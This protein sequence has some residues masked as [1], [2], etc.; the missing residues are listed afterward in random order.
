MGEKGVCV[1]IIFFIPFF[2]FLFFSLYLCVL[3]QTKGI[4]V[5]LLNFCTLN[6]Q[7]ERVSSQKELWCRR[8]KGLGLLVVEIKGSKPYC[9]NLQRFMNPGAIYPY[10]KYTSFGQERSVEDGEISL[11]IS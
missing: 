2:L 8:L 5:I 1:I 7:T 10:L 3:N 9:Y 11:N 4:V 6:D